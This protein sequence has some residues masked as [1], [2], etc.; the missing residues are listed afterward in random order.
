MDTGI[1]TGV[2]DSGIGTAFGDILSNVNFQ[3]AGTSGNTAFSIGS[4]PSGATYGVPQP[5]YGSFSS[6]LKNGSPQGGFFVGIP[7]FLLLAVGG[8]LAYVLF[9]KKRRV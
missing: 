9:F 6:W 7:G 1:D 4:A 3:V 5:I 2:S 8:I